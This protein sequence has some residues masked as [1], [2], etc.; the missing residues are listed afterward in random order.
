M[1][2]T[3]YPKGSKNG[4][5]TPKELDHILTGWEGEKLAESPGLVGSVRIVSDGS[6]TIDFRYSMKWKGKSAWYYCG[7]YPNISISEI[8][9][10]RD[11]AKK[12]LKEGV[13]PRVKS[14][15]VRIQKREEAQAVLDREALRVANALT[16]KDMFDDWLELKGVSRKDANKSIRQAFEKH[17]FPFIGNIE[18]R[19]L[20]DRDLTKIYQKLVS[21]GKATTAFELSKDV[22]QMLKWAEKRKPYRQLM[23]EGNPADL[24]DIWN[25]LPSGFTKIRERVLPIEQLVVLRKRF[26]EL[27]EN[28]RNAAKKYGTVRPIKKEVE[29]ALWLNLGCLTRIGETL[30]AEWRHISFDNRTWFIPKEN[31]KKER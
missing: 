24:V 10:R 25:I 19:L 27:E 15:A 21:D 30:K 6:A 11:A 5:W 13:D 1:G 18:V 22:K 8:R 4:K 14:A 12:S 3:R 16:V 23:I 9:D 20:A 31:T 7:S 28:Y 2:K 29:I 17:I 26:I